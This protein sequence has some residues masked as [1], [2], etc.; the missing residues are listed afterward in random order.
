MSYACVEL[1]RKVLGRLEG[2]TVGIVGSGEMAELSAEHMQKAGVG[3][4]VFFNRSLGSAKKLS[5]RFGGHVCAL[6]EIEKDLGRCD[7]VVSSTGSPEVVLSREQVRAAMRQR[8]NQAMFLI[9]IAAPRDI[10]PAVAELTNAFLFTID[11]L[12]HV[13]QENVAPSGR[14]GPRSHG[15]CERKCR[16]DRSLVS[17]VWKCGRCCVTFGKK[18]ERLVEQELQNLPADLDD[19]AREKLENSC[20]SLMNRFLHEPVTNLKLMGE[21][22]EGRRAVYYAGKMFGLDSTNADGEGE[23]EH[24][25][26]V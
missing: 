11:D 22:G 25:E 13:V 19:A 15:A 9:D 3:D 14:R 20:R 5:Q 16:G 1:A 6:S 24:D 18:Y 8:H 7:M 4:F 21:N 10:D 12:K 23:N 26:G 17:G 2:K